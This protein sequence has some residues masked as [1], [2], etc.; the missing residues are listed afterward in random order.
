MCRR[1]SPLRASWRGRRTSPPS[2][3]IRTPSTVR[4]DSAMSVA[5]TTRR[6]PAGD[7]ARA[8][9]C[10]SGRRLPCSGRTSTSR[11]RSASNPPTRRM[12]AAPGRNT[13]TS[14]LSSRTASCTTAATASKG[15]TRGPG[16][17]QRMSTGWVRPGLVTTGAGPAVPPSRTASRVASSVADMASNRRS[18]RR[19]SRASR[20]SASARSVCRCRS[21]TSSKTTSAVPG[22][23]GSAWSRRVRIPS[24]TTSIR[25]AGP[26]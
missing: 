7:G 23:L 15:R 24:V 5:S 21:W 10:S 18:G 8:R 12:A 1:L 19:P 2:T 14:P 13:S 3:T 6:R 26:T 16:G 20:A 9:S 11:G 4:L 17:R 22:R 25:V